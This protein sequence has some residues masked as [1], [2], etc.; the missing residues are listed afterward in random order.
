MVPLNSEKR[1]LRTLDGPQMLLSAHSARDHIT[2]SV[3]Q[4]TQVRRGGAGLNTTLYV[5]PG[6]PLGEHAS[7][8]R[9]DYRFLYLPLSAR[10]GGRKGTALWREGSGTQRATGKGSSAARE[11]LVTRN[12]AP[13]PL[14]VHSSLLPSLPQPDSAQGPHLQRPGSPPMV[15]K[16]REDM[17]PS[18]SK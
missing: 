2:H 11:E 1:C 3:T 16:E 6:A 7:T 8:P 10:A 15:C 13:V 5:T 9:D 18:I 4:G 14:S 17:I 12:P